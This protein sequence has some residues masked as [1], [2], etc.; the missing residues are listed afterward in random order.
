MLTQ[1]IRTRC[2]QRGIKEAGLDLLIQ[3]GTQIHR[4]VIL[5]R[6][7]IADAKR[8]LKHQIDCLEKL[9]G[10]CVVMDGDARIT[11]YRAHDAWP[12]IS[13][14]R[15]KRDRRGARVGTAGRPR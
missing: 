2:Q 13:G 11:T 15:R 8:E 7:D 14:I 5:T 1:H 3:Y 6:K 4:G 9:E 10:V 12:A